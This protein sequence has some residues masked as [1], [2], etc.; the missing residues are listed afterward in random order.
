MTGHSPGRPPSVDRV[1]YR[2]QKPVE[3]CI[4]RLNGYCVLA[5]W[6]VKPESPTAP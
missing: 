1:R 2:D 6:Y 5:I 4:I 3:R